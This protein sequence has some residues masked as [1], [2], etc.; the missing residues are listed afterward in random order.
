MFWMKKAKLKLIC[1][2]TD[3]LEKTKKQIIS[4]WF[5]LERTKAVPALA[6]IAEQQVQM[7][8]EK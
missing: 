3:L 7:Y 8:R 1:N 6:T 2:Y 5:A 4:Q